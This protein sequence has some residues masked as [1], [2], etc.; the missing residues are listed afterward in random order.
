MNDD[1]NV[2][3]DNLYT[4][5]TGYRRPS[6]LDASPTRDPVAIMRDL[7]SAPLRELP[8]NMIG[9]YA[10]HALTTV[11]SASAYRHFLPRIIELCI[12][13]NGWMG[14]EPEQIART[15]NYG[16]WRTWAEDAQAAILRA[17]VTGW[18]KTRAE[19]PDDFNSVDVL[20]A[21]AI[22]G[23]DVA[24]LLAEWTTPSSAGE[25][26]QM[27]GH[28]QTAAELDSWVY[29]KQAGAANQHALWNWA[30]SAVVQA[31][32]EEGA[33]AFAADAVLWEIDRARL[34]ISASAAPD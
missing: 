20:C 22:L 4:V 27:A 7:S 6:R 13:R 23:E 25:V 34:D 5:F 30:R 11:G 2:A 31:G 16:H 10:G 14:L 15:L 8:A 26:R 17:F 19:T 3:I 9:P 28:V 33:I 21:L 24:L 32:L 1:W 29:W 12:T 18:F